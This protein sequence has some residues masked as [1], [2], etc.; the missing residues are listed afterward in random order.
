MPSPGEMAERSKA[1][2]LK[3]VEEKILP[4]FES[5]SLR[6]FRFKAGGGYSRLMSQYY[7]NTLIQPS[8]TPFFNK[9]PASNNEAQ[10]VEPLSVEIEY[11]DPD[12]LFSHFST[13]IWSIFL[14][15][16]KKMPRLAQYSFIAIEP[17]K[18]LLAYGEDCYLD[19]E[20]VESCPFQCLKEQL[21]RYTLKMIKNRPP[22][23][24]GVLGY[25][26]Y[27]AGGYLEVL[28]KPKF[29]Q[30]SHETSH[31]CKDGPN[32]APDIAMGFYDVVI[33]FDHTTHRAWIFSS[34][35]PKQERAQQR[36][37]EM[38]QR[39][40]AVRNVVVNEKTTPADEPQITDDLNFRTIK[41]NFTRAGYEEAVQKTIKH[42]HQGDIFEAN[43]SQCFE[44]PRPTTL[45]PYLLYQHLRSIN[46][47]PFSAYLNLP[48]VILASTSPECFLKMQQNSVQTFPIKG[49]RR[50]S[51]NPTIDSQLADELKSSVKDR[52]E[53]MMIVDL[54]RNDLSRVC[55]DH[56]VSVPQRCVL[57][58]FEGVHHLVSEVNGV[59]RPDC[60]A[61]DLLKATFP[62]GSITGAPKIRSQE[63]IH[64]IEPH[65]RGPY[66]GSTLY[67]GFDGNMDSAIL[68]RSL[69][70]ERN[71]IRF[72]TGGAIVSDSNPSD[73]YD[74][75]LAKAAAL[76]RG[77]EALCY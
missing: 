6:N 34:G 16:S 53:N 71:H 40:D 36:L 11:I 39:I 35:F 65:A 72:H 32:R 20:K 33:A 15:S 50:R 41:S 26:G 66:C 24:G 59:L 2:V 76:K 62:G 21:K 56:S 49:T 57:E 22:L 10:V 68:I 74:E 7:S 45:D 48:N 44:T 19:D 9:K 47:T 30:K 1:A 67:I 23:Q 73:E 28:P 17:F 43:I 77:L 69:V 37:T 38:Q 8:I 63:I 5:L 14:D 18:T 4:G 75:T 27:E 55:L 46:P 64:D 58:S 31:V 3:T 13:D 25:L 54:L 29:T 61:V 60:D 51:S 42:I 12:R 70:I 52:A